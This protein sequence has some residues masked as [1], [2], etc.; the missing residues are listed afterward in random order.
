[1]PWVLVSPG[2]KTGIW[3]KDFSKEWQNTGK[4]PEWG[5]DKGPTEAWGCR[6]LLP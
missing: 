5:R 2:D 1:M 4:A 6:V 3:G